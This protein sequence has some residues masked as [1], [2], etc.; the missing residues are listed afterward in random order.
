[1]KQIGGPGVALA[2]W[3]CML[4]LESAVVF[5]ISGLND[6][7]WLLSMRSKANKVILLLHRSS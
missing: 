5:T 3:A 1:M 7:C 6:T 4:M 2:K